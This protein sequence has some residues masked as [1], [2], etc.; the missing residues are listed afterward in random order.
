MEKKVENISKYHLVLIVLIRN[1]IIDSFRMGLHV[2]CRSIKKYSSV[3]RSLGRLIR[4]TG[5]EYAIGL[6][7][8]RNNLIFNF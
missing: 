4:D 7:V 8:Y 3:N 2:V 5:F 6:I 1:Y